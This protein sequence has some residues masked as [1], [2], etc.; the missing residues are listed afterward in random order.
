MVFVREKVESKSL[1]LRVKDKKN[2]QVIMSVKDDFTI[3]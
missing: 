3:K 1:D 2:K